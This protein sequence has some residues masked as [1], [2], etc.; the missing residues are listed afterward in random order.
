M[1]STVQIL[2][3]TQEHIDSNV[4]HLSRLKAELSR[5]RETL[6]RATVACNETRKLLATVQIPSGSAT[7]PED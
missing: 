3:A 2:I 1:M 7:D 6:Q 4:V 5:T